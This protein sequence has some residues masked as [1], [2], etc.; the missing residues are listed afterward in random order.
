MRR[1]LYIAAFVAVLLIACIGGVLGGR[2]LLQRLQGDFTSR[3]TTTAPTRSI[4]PTPELTAAPT[5]AA[6]ES[7]P[8]PAA[9]APRATR[10]VLV[11]PAPVTDQPTLFTPE[12]TWTPGVEL[13]ANLPTLALPGS[14]AGLPALT[15]LAEGEGTPAPSATALPNFPYVLAHTVRYTSGDCPGTY[16]LGIVTDRAGNPLPGIHINMTDEYGNV[17]TAATKPGPG[18]TGRYDFPMGGPARRFYMTIVDD[19]GRPQSQSV[20]ILHDLPP[21]EGKGCRWVDWRRS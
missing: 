7:T 21:Q 4:S 8:E 19:A 9:T 3:P 20:E 14:G 6:A 5:A 17:F 2:I 18:D 12:P 13:P 15:P 16:A 11:V 10:T 1:N